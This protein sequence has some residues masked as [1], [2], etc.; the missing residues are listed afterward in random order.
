M[1]IS[2]GIEEIDTQVRPYPFYKTY[3]ES[4]GEKID[5]LPVGI[6]LVQLTLKACFSRVYQVVD[7]LDL[8]PVPIYEFKDW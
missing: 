4:V 8:R 1:M 5:R 7:V 2:L 3:R 6:R